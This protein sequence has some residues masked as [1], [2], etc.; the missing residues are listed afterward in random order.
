MGWFGRQKN[1]GDARVAE[2]GVASDLADFL[3]HATEAG[4]LRH[5]IDAG[6]PLTQAELN[7][8]SSVVLASQSGQ[9]LPGAVARLLGQSEAARVADAEMRR[10]STEEAGDDRRHEL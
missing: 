4:A 3:V 6:V 1:S 7:T 5:A 9:T 8:P 2:T 10:T